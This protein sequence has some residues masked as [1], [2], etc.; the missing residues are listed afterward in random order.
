MKPT[1]DSRLWGGR[2]LQGKLS[3]TFDADYYL[4]MVVWFQLQY[5]AEKKKQDTAAVIRTVGNKTSVL[6]RDL[7]GSSTYYMSLRAYNSAGVGPQSIIVNVT[8]KKPRKGSQH[9]VGNDFLCTFFF[10]SSCG[11][12]GTYFISAI[13]FHQLE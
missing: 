1:E 2:Q 4:C 7:E 11:P 13:M 10:F 12:S 8:T 9:S 6:V 3:N 5:W